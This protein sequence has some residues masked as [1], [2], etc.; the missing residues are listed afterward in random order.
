M[1]TIHPTNGDRSDIVIDSKYGFGES[2]VSGE[3]TPDHFVVI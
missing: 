1:F 2:V 3:V